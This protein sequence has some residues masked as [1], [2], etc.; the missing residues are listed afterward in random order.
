MA[1][2]AWASRA[3]VSLCNRIFQFSSTVVAAI[4]VGMDTNPKRR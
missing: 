4:V 1:V 2:A 3:M